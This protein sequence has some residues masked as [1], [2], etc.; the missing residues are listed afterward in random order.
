[1]AVPSMF[2]FFW[3]R[4]FVTAFMQR[5]TCKYFIQINTNMNV[6]PRISIGYL[7]VEV[8]RPCSQIIIMRGIQFVSTAWCVIYVGPTTSKSTHSILKFRFFWQLLTK[9]YKFN[10]SAYEYTTSNR[11]SFVISNFLKTE[12]WRC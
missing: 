1:M 3:L 6:N 10:L 12:F 8:V 7:S 11:Q 2:N 5:N 9:K 4:A